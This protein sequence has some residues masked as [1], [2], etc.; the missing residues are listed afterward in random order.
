VVGIVAFLEW[1]LGM[2]G[3]GSAF[4]GGDRDLA[5]LLDEDTQTWDLSRHDRRHFAFPEWAASIPGRKR[6]LRELDLE[7]GQL[8]GRW[9]GESLA[10][11]GLAE[12]T[13]AYARW[14]T[15]VLTRMIEEEGFGADEVPDL[16]FTNYKVIDGT[17]HRWSN[18]SPQMDAA[19]RASDDALGDIVDLLDREVGPGRW[20]LALTADHGVS[21]VPTDDFI[22]DTAELADDVEARFDSDD[23]GRLAQVTAPSQMWLDPALLEDLRVTTEEV[24]AYVARYRK[25]QNVADPSAIP[26][27]RERLFAA[28]FPGSLLDDLPCL[29]AR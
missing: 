18:D 28:A 10:L 27:G 13:P 12:R 6:H 26:D 14:Q 1:H 24:A 2:L 22:V 4:P 29:S 21:P 5:V 3:H 8:D 15:E 20:I 19:V 16:L 17:G 23:A 11:P 9:L 25:A 7:D